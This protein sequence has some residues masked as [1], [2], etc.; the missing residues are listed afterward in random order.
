MVLCNIEDLRLQGFVWCGKYFAELSQIFGARSA[1]PNYDMLG[2]TVSALAR[3]VSHIPKALVHRQLDD[4]PTVAPAFTNWCQQFTENYKEVCAIIG[5]QLAEECPD[6][7]KAFCNST[8]GK[9]LGINFNTKDLTWNLP[10]DKR[11][12]YGNMIHEALSAAELS[13]DDSQK[14]VGKL[15]FVCSMAQW[16]RTF[17]RPL[18][19]FQT[20]LEESAMQSGL[21]PEEVRKDLKFW[22]AFITSQETL[23]VPI[24][25]PTGAP[26][27]QHK[28]F[29]TD[30]AGW[31]RDGSSLEVGMG[32]VGLDEKGEIIFANQTLWTPE[33][34]IS[35]FDGKG[36]YMGNKT[37]TL[38]F[39]GILVPFLQCPH[40]MTGNHIVVGVDNI[41]CLYAWERGYSKDDNTASV[42]VRTLTMLCAKLS[43]VVHVVHVPRDTTW[44]SKLVNRLS[45]QI[46][47]S[48]S[49]KALLASFSKRELP[50][51][52]KDWMMSPTEEWD[53]YLKIIPT[54]NPYLAQ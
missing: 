40:M 25:H 42:L 47:T 38:E 36:K 39:A 19:I 27:L 52:F 20:S 51:P 48:Q 10:E 14:L 43:C 16:A 53:L 5:I 2:N 46:T 26:T 30:A 31:K 45:R 23:Q 33:A 29:T 28:T 22:W 35:F 3:A 17:L 4:V 9:V 1:V 8:N 21:L 34:V 50:R 12:E 41:S 54:V 32:C 15:T 13:L 18:Q 37:T 24:A 7:D 6:K 11:L 44:E 49:D